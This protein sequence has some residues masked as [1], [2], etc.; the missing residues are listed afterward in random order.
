[1][2][3][4]SSPVPLTRA[5]DGEQLLNRE[6]LDPAF[7]ERVYNALR[8]GVRQADVRIGKLDFPDAG[9]GGL[10]DVRGPHEVLLVPPDE[11]ARLFKGHISFALH[12]K[13]TTSTEACQV[14]FMVL[15]K[16]LCSSAKSLQLSKFT[17]V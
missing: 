10:S 11:A 3:A 7:A 8:R 5:L 12:R 17:V 13:D 6:L 2:A 9:D 16:I 15:S 14:V 4:R 1:M